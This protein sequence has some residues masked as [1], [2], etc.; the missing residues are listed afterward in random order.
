MAATS[1]TRSEEK[2]RE[3]ESEGGGKLEGKEETRAAQGLILAPRRS[4]VACIPVGIGRRRQLHRAASL[5][6]EDNGQRRWAR[7]LLGCSLLH[8]GDK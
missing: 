2:W 7:P 6:Q 5:L 4:A 1:G 3:G 8:A